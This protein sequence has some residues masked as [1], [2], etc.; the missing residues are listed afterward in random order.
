MADREESAVFTP[1]Q[2]LCRT[3]PSGITILEDLPT[4]SATGKR[5][6]ESPGEEN[7]AAKPR[8]ETESDS[9]QVV[10]APHYGGKEEMMRTVHDSVKAISALV[11]RDPNLTKRTSAASRPTATRYW[12]LSRR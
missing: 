4:G 10:A 7:L 5:P 2:S 9:E 1:R 6:R 12:R 11:A 8:L 3:P